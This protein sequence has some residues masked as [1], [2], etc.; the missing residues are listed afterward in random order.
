MK[1]AILFL[2]VTAI[3]LSISSQVFALEGH[4][5]N[6][7][8]QSN[9]QPVAIYLDRGVDNL[10]VLIGG[11]Y[12]VF[13]ETISGGDLCGSYT[14]YGPNEAKISGKILFEKTRTIT[15]SSRGV[16]GG[17]ETYITFQCD[18]G[19]VIVKWNK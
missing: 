3:F 14:V 18:N 15:L 2:V 5:I 1:K 6:L 11:R 4:K 12:D 9:E 10:G 7:G 17:G 16:L 8:D 19:E 13:V